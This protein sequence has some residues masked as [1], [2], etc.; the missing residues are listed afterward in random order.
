[1]FY[2]LK[3]RGVYKP[4]PG[5]PLFLA[6]LSGALLL[7]A[8]VGMMIA[9]QFDWIAMKN[10]PLLRIGALLMIVTICVVS[11]FGSLLA[12]GF[13]FSDFKRSSD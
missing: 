4:E 12:M 11:Y 2:F 6:R 8:A 3:K 13:R 5:W 10:T 1:L 7:L 9:A